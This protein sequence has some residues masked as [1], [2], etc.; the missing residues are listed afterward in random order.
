[1]KL[2]TTLSTAVSNTSVSL[3]R[4]LKY[5]KGD[6]RTNYLIEIKNRCDNLLKE[7]KQKDN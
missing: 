3:K 5:L 4:G 2:V 7:E 1:M 6:D